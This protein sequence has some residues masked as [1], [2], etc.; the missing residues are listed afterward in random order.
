MV[1]NP[2][3]NNG[4]NDY[5]ADLEAGRPL[6]ST[7]RTTGS[8]MKL[9]LISLSAVAVTGLAAALYF[10]AYQRGLEDGQNSNPPLIAADPGPIRVTPEVAGEAQAPPQ[11]LAIYGIAQGKP[12]S[13]NGARESLMQSDAKPAETAPKVAKEAVPGVPGAMPMTEPPKA[14]AGAPSSKPDAGS[15]ASVAGV[16]ATEPVTE[17]MAAPP[18]TEKMSESKPAPKPDADA[19]MRERFMVQVAAT[20]SRA[21]ARSTFGDMQKK[22]PQL[23][24]GRDPLILRI[25]LGP[26]GIFYRVNIGGFENR[27]DA[28]EFCASLKNAGQDCLVKNEPT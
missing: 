5:D 7:Q 4:Q 13:N 3:A 14:G 10:Y 11:D 25:D 22:Y 26:K 28:I 21:L 19:L 17:P 23:L 8:F 1:N 24:S 18:A 20:R 6:Y 12:D 15:N 16:A 9:G 27:G 2:L